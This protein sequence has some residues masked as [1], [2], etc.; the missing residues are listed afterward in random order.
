MTPDW[1]IYPNYTRSLVYAKHLTN[2]NILI[3]IHILIFSSEIVF[4]IL[5]AGFYFTLEFLGFTSLELPCKT[6]K[7]AQP[8]VSAR[9]RW[10]WWLE[11]YF[12]CGFSHIVWIYLPRSL[13]FCRCNKQCQFQSKDFTSLEYSKGFTSLE[14]SKGFTSLEYS[15]GFSSLEYSKGFTSLEYSKGFTYLEYSKGFTTLEYSKWFHFS[16][17]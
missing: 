6:L 12:I 11:A 5:H 8:T 14:Y 16:R 7:F 10:F 13:K 17:V 3:F 2:N 9:F 15:K 4:F 1:E